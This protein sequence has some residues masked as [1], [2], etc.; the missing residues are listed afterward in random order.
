MNLNLN[1][2]PPSSKQ[3]ISALPF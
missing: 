2:Y 3:Y 1:Q